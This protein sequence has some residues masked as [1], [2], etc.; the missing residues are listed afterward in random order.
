M[1]INMLGGMYG[2]ESKKKKKIYKKNS[3]GVKNLLDLIRNKQENVS[4]RPIFFTLA[5]MKCMEI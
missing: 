1:L 2:R 3:V 4:D 5:L